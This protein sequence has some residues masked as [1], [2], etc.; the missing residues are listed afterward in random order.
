MKT[1]LTLFLLT[2]SLFAS[3]DA[4][5]LDKIAYKAIEE[6]FAKK[7]LI[8]R[9][10]VLEYFP[11]LSQ[12]A[13]V[14]VT[15]RKNGRL[16]GCVGSLQPDKGLL[17]AVIDNAKK[18][19]FGDSR[20]KPVTLDELKHLTIEVAV[21]SPLRE[22]LYKDSADLRKKIDKN[23]GIWLRLGD[24]SATYLPSVWSELQDF[25]AF[26]A[27]LCEKASLQK[28]CLAEHPKIYAYTVKKYSYNVKKMQKAGDFYPKWCEELQET[29]ASYPLKER[30]PTALPRAFVV[31]HAGYIY[32]AKTANEAYRYIKDA[33][34]IERVVVVAPSHH[35]AFKG[36]SVL[37][38]DAYETPC[39]ELTVDKKYIA[40]LKKSFRFLYEKKA[41][42]KEHA[43]E[44][45]MPLIHYYRPDM[46]VVEIL[47][48]QIESATLA[49]LLERLLRDKTTLVVISSDLS[50]YHTLKEAN[51][52]DRICIDALER[53]NR[54]ILKEG[55]E[56][57]GYR[58]IEALI[59]AARKL[60]LHVKI[61]DYDTSYSY[62]KTSKSVV[63]YLSAIVY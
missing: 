9:D 51:R 50:H 48:S 62:T 21:L 36:L 34:E 49:R 3:Y 15:L 29:I 63:G 59:V 4:K 32:S 43:G 16:R 42:K 26:F 33:Q 35:V 17:Y 41:H 54:L 58:G 12:K 20:F 5:L 44:V 6:E 7:P 61:L 8:N 27:S 55:C 19:A 10:V 39:G 40:E 28:G 18:A 23:N 22:V 11:E 31:P 46:K 52:L 1:I 38:V 53:K 13:A 56:A 37:E 24:K 25:D 60:G 45:Q 14:F 30:L 57:C 2:L 47:Y